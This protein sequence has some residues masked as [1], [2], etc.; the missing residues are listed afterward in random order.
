MQYLKIHCC[1]RKSSKTEC[2]WQNLGSCVWS[3]ESQ[4][5]TSCMV[6]LRSGVLKNLPRNVIINTSLPQW[7]V[8][9]E[10]SLCAEAF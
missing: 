7:S 8:E 5:N 1:F 6:M 10:L 9:E 2:F 4:W 3:D